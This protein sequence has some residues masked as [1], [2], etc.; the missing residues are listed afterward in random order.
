M[1]FSSA[2][3]AF[4][5]QFP[6]LS[7][8][9][10]RSEGGRKALLCASNLCLSL[11]GLA[12]SVSGLRGVW[13]LLNLYVPIGSCPFKTLKIKST[14]PRSSESHSVSLAVSSSSAFAIL[15]LIRC[16]SSLHAHL[17]GKLKNKPYLS[18]Q[19]K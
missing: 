18:I 16:A 11:L 12:S 1:G 4:C 7:A 10:R 14:P 6:M 17:V 15:V 3:F 9:D 2:L 19:L 13:I 5:A 8:L